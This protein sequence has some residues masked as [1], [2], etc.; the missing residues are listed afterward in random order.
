MSME[1]NYI[2]TECA[3]DVDPASRGTVFDIKRFALHDGPGIRTSVFLKGCPLR[4]AWCHNPE[5]QVLDPQVLVD[6]TMC[7]RCGACIE[8]CPHGAA[9]QG[10]DRMKPE[11]A[12]C[13]AC[14]ACTIACPQD[15]RHLAGKQLSVPQVMDVVS[16]DTVYYASEGGVTLSGGEP[17]SQPEFAIAL[18]EACSHQ[19]IHR[20]VDTCGFAPPLVVDAVATRANLIL[21]DLK[22]MDDGRHLSATGCSNRVI[23]DNLR[24]LDSR[25]VTL[26]IRIPIIPGLN[27]DRENLHDISQFL[28]S[29]TSIQRVQLLPYHR[30]GASKQ[31]RWGISPTFQAQPHTPEHLAKLLAFVQ[32]HCPHPVTLGGFT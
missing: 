15:A 9:R 6:H 12:P 8:A 22:L 23:L 24:L 27:D 21:Y 19:G 18:L 3:I 5:S 7:T 28:S 30:G 11:S 17:L 14:G 10:N 2:N 13:T 4:C 1:T 20:A 26:W 32:S 29:L 16:A 25:E 31:H